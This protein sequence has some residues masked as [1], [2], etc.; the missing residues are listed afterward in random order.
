LG[1]ADALTGIVGVMKRYANHTSAWL[2]R[3]KNEDAE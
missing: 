2:L 3:R 1:Y